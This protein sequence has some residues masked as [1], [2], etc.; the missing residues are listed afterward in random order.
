[1]RART[2]NVLLRSKLSAPLGCCSSA[3]NAFLPL[4]SRSAKA[5]RN[6]HTR[7][8]RDTRAPTSSPSPSPGAGRAGLRRGHVGRARTA[9]PHRR[10]ERQP[11]G[12]A[13]R[14]PVRGLRTRPFGALGGGMGVCVV[15]EVGVSSGHRIGRSNGAACAR[16]W[17]PC[18]PHFL[19]SPVMYSTRFFFECHVFAVGVWG[20]MAPKLL[21]PC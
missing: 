17:Q 1:M 20:R 19:R 7:T 21:V 16:R 6:T 5:T 2:R 12:E 15:S 10:G 9:A 14:H 8:H 11:P 13:V 4:A 18:S 3:A